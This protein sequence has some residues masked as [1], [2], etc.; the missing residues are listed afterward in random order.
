MSKPF[1][2][3]G[4][5]PVCET[6]LCGVR[7]IVPTDQPP[8]PLAVCDECEAMWTT[9]DLSQEP[10]FS[11]A[12]AAVNPIDGLPLWG[13]DAHWA[14]LGECDR[15]GWIEAIDPGLHYHGTRPEHDDPLVSLDEGY[16]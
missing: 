6:G 1:H 12:E 10:L 3:I 2:S 14:D 15:V 5:C 13:P 16:S 11:S 7:I 8:Y 4:I 9:P